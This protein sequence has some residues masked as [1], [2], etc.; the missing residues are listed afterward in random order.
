MS[1]ALLHDQCVDRFV[2]LVERGAPVVG[3][4]IAEINGDDEVSF[5]GNVRSLMA[6]CA[7]FCEMLYFVQYSVLVLAWQV[8]EFEL[9]LDDA[10]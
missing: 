2:D 10:I 9:Q 4:E 5:L 6:V 7:N 3:F 8:L 1:V